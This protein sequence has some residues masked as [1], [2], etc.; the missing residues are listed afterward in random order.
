MTKTL[1]KVIPVE[2]VWLS[3]R[4]VKKYLDISERT[5]LRLHTD[6]KIHFYKPFNNVTIYYRKSEIDR[7]IMK[8][9]VI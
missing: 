7:L 9:K 3:G 6:G 5:L 4:E 8:G 1:G 2:K